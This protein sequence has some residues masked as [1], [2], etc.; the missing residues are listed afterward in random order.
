MAVYKADR[1]LVEG[2][3]RIAARGLNFRL[4]DAERKDGTGELASRFNEMNEELVNYNCS[5]KKLKNR[6][7]LA[8]L[9]RH[10]HE[11]CNPLNYINLSLDHLHRKFEPNEADR[12]EIFEKLTSRLKAEVKRINRQTSDFLRYSRPMKL[13]LWRIYIRSMIEGSLSLIEPQAV[14][15]GVKIRSVEREG[16]FRGDWRAGSLTFGI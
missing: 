11:I 5:F 9:L 15:Q 7:W 3:K 13:D 1:K 16:L 10:A 2:C 4:K 14:E 8:D 6:Q 12:R